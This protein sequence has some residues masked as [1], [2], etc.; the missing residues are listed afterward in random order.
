MH[1]KIFTTTLG[2]SYFLSQLVFMERK[3]SSFYSKLCFDFGRVSWYSVSLLKVCFMG[4][5]N[6]VIK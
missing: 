2:H 5:K 6:L 4:G 3:K 1:F